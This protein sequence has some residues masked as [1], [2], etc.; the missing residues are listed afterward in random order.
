MLMCATAVAQRSVA[1]RAGLSSYGHPSI[2]I[3]SIADDYAAIQAMLEMVDFRSAADG[4]GRLDSPYSHAKTASPS[5]VFW[6]PVPLKA[7]AIAPQF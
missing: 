5:E 1:E 2:G 7:V 6:A 3:Q 4:G